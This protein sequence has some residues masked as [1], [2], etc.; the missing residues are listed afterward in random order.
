MR[1]IENLRIG[2]RAVRANALRSALAMLGIIIG[3]AAV[4]AMTAIGYG[5]QKQ[6]T[7]RIRSLGT[8]VALVA[9]GSTNS[10]GV[11]STMGA[12]LSLTEDDANAIASQLPDVVVA[13]PV[14]MGNGHLI[15]GNQNWAT[16]VG[17][18]T[19]E[20]LVARDWSVREGRLFTAEEV[21]NASK[22]VLLGASVVKKLFD[23]KKVVGAIVRIGTVPFTVVGILS[24]KGQAAAAGRDQDDVA[25]V[26]LATA[27]LRVLGGRNPVNRQSVD[28]ILVKARAEDALPTLMRNIRV[29]LRQVHRLSPDAEDDFQVREPAAAMEAQAAATR[30]LTM[31]LAAIASVSLVVGGIGIMNIMLVSV[32][33]RTREIGLRQALG[34]RRRDIR[35]QFLAEVSLLCLLGGLVGITTGVASAALI[36]NLAGWP[37]FLDAWAMIVGIVFAAAVGLVFGLFPAQKAARMHIVDALRYE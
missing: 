15:Y 5:A 22:V 8:N 35:N 6:V 30:T 12:H 33:E 16:I 14:I 17:G 11:R 26:P 19:P 24:E 29:L 10:N 18:I 23:G 2:L 3:V 21:T 7:D 4:I 32:T 20:Y 27:K 34:A 13:A 9:P 25:F 31:L 1:V 37:I 28:L 36:S